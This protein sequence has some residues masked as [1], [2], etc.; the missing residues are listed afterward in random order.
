MIRT[1]ELTQSIF[2][3]HMRKNFATLGADAIIHIHRLVEH[4]IN[5]PQINRLEKKY[6]KEKVESMLK[7]MRDFHS[8]YSFSEE[9]RSVYEQLNE[10]DADYA[11]KRKRMMNDLMQIS[12]RMPICEMTLMQLFVDLT[13]GTDLVSIRPSSASDKT[14]SRRR[15]RFNE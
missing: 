7:I 11:K 3:E 9:L 8:I 10:S 14:E 5:H 4:L 6:G 1:D 2:R 15:F 13:E 12:T